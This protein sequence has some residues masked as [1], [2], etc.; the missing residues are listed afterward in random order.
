MD[1]NQQ[2]FGENIRVAGSELLESIKRLVEAGNVRTLILWGD[3]DRKL[4]EINLNAGIALGGATLL[5]AP[6]VAAILGIAAVVKH[7]RIEV[8][9]KDQDE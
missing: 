9:R 3:D 7:V 6:F 2:Q 5:L 1:N 4:L 8:V